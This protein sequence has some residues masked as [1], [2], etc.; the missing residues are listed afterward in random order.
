MSWKYQWLSGIAAIFLLLSLGI[1]ETLADVNII[2]RGTVIEPAC[3]VTGV[4]GN[5]QTEV[6]FGNVPLKAVGTV[7]AQRSLKMKVACDSAPPTGKTLKM[8]V[9]PGSN[10][11]MAYSGRV[12]LGT[13]M[14]WLGID[15]ADSDNQVVTPLTW[16]HIAGVDTS[17]ATPTGVVTLQAT[18]VSANIAMLKADGFVSSAS[19]MMT[20]Q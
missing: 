14:T 13:S 12:V 1:H 7:Q 3:S 20:Y 18:L 10:G 8:Y 15:L 19:V 2:I 11:T 6:D 17:A 4:D 5:S 16:V 9:R